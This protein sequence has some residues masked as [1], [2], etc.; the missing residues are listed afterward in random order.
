MGKRKWEGELRLE[1]LSRS[2]K[3]R[4]KSALPLLLVF[5]PILF[6]EDRI[7]KGGVVMRSLMASESVHF[8]F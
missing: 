2:G 3:K 1:V 8:H 4:R 6:I 5:P 7:F